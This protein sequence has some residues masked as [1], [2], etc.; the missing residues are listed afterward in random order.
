MSRTIPAERLSAIRLLA[1][2]SRTRNVMAAVES[3][4][5][6]RQYERGVAVRGGDLD[7][8]YIVVDGHT[9]LRGVEVSDD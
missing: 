6:R 1:E 3:H 7:R 8:L 5:V 4:T 9:Y 2:A